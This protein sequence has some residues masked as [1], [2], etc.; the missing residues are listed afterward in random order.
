MTISKVKIGTT[1]HDLA[2]T[3]LTTSRLIALSGSVSGSAY[4]DG[5]ADVNIATSISDA[6]A[7]K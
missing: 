6:Y 2:A 3:K 4:F 1:E 5:N 7:T